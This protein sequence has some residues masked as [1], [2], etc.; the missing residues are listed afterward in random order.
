M[1]IAKVVI[2]LKINS[3]DYLIPDTLLSEVKVGTLVNVKVKEMGFI[4][5][6][7]EIVDSSPFK[8]RPI[9]SVYEHLNLGE[10]YVAFLKWISKYYYIP[11]GKVIEF[12]LPIKEKNE[13]VNHPL[14]KEE[15]IEKTDL[16]DLTIALN[17]F[18]RLSQKEVVQ[19]IDSFDKISLAD[20]K[21]QFKA[22][23]KTVLPKLE[24]LNFIYTKEVVSW[25][26]PDTVLTPSRPNNI[27]LTDDQKRI[28]NEVTPH[29]VNT[30]FYPYLIKGVTGSGKTEIYYQLIKKTIEAKKTALILLPE[31]A[32]TDQ[33]ISYFLDLVNFSEIALIHSQL[34]RAQK[35][36]Y[37]YN[38]ANNKI[39]VVIGARSAIFAPLE[40]IGLIIVDEEQDSSYKQSETSF[41]YNARDLAVLLAN[42][43]KAP[44]VLGTATPS[45]ETMNNVVTNKYHQGLLP[46]RINQMPL[47]DIEIIDLTE[48]DILVEKT[49]ISKPLYW[50]LKD[51][52]QR[53]E[54]AIIYLNKRGYHANLVCKDCGYSFKCS[55]CDITYTYYKYENKLKCHYCTQEIMKPEFCPQCQS[56][57]IKNLSIGTEKVAEDLK[58]L[59]PDTKIDR[60]DRDIITSYPKLAE[61]IKKVKQNETTILIGTQMV[62]KGHHFPNV[63][64]VAVL[65]ADQG[66]TFPDIRSAEYSFHDFIQVSGRAGRA[67]KKG[68]VL[69]QTYMKNHYTIQY[70]VQQK[71][72]EFYKHELEW[73]KA[74][75]YPPFYKMVNIL[76]SSQ[77]EKLLEESI[78]KINQYNPIATIYLQATKASVFKINNIFRY[79]IQIKSM[80]PSAIDKEMRSL[81]KHLE[82]L[83]LSSKIDIIIDRDPL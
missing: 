47:P 59:F 27:R 23:L 64:L 72:D 13:K 11:E 22:R 16:F 49:L 81:L 67:E 32:L 71:I 18:S 40:N 46:E 4:G 12:M 60:L 82:K 41:R 6:V 63:T 74:L 53:K 83:K 61:V 2:P 15:F 52:V 38:V 77:D 14:K 24:E 31:I 29:I 51:I 28:I 76:I 62:V 33:T 58:T 44:I 8:L 78:A 9:V 55:N 21:E 54:Q 20:L 3:F 39:K 35:S 5:I 56:K 30:E 34:T 45:L 42:L 79:I 26:M 73:R 50:A 7:V 10:K 66:I 68:K 75:N 80:Q 37:W 65:L 25:V 1:N 57:R 43:H 19:H 17:L 69:I 48:K 70:F 36:D